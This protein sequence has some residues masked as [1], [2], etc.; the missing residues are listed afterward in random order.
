MKEF[1]KVRFF[2]N[3][4]LTRVLRAFTCTWVRITENKVV[5]QLIDDSIREYKLKSISDLE[6]TTLY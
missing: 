4:L 1:L 2:E 6:I 5:F 3:Y